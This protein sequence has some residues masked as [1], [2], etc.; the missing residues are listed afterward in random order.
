MAHCP[1]CR[2]SDGLHSAPSRDGLAADGGLLAADYKAG[3]CGQSR[4]VDGEW[5]P[6][7]CPGWYPKTTT[8]ELVRA[9]QRAASRRID[10]RMSAYWNEQ[11]VRLNGEP[12]QLGLF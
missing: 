11:R 3:R 7:P 8:K 6:C 5:V 10:A 12:Q 9:T 4:L 1:H 2:H